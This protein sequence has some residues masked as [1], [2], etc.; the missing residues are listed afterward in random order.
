MRNKIVSL[1]VTD[2]VR[3]WINRSRWFVEKRVER[4]NNDELCEI[5]V[6]IN[7]QS[8]GGPKKKNKQIYLERNMRARDVDEGTTVKDKEEE[9]RKIATN[10]SYGQ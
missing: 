4:K 2:V 1:G 3:K 9:K 5:R 8:T 7:W 6:K 10:L